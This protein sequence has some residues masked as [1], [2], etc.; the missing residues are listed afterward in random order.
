MKLCGLWALHCVICF[1]VGYGRQSCLCCLWFQWCLVLICVSL[2][3]LLVVCCVVL[4]LGNVSYEIWSGV[5]KW[6]NKIDTTLSSL[7][8]FV[9]F[10]SWT[11]SLASR[12]SRFNFKGCSLVMV[13]KNDHLPWTTFLLETLHF[14][15]TMCF[16]GRNVGL[17]ANDRDQLRKTMKCYRGFMNDMCD[18]LMLGGK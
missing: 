5:E 17:D 1:L 7:L 14:C 2:F 10:E 12:F 8:M 6:R 13:G 18:K 9:V 11:V 3:F 16:K 15:C 4:C